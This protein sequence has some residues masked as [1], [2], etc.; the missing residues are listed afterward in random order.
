V[1]FEPVHYDAPSAAEIA[2]AG[3]DVA[4]V[5][6]GPA[7]LTLALALAQREIS[8][9]V[10]EQRDAV[11]IGSRALGLTRRTLDIWEQLGVGDAV[12]SIGRTWYGG[13]SFFREQLILAHELPHDPTLKHAPM[14]NLQQCIAEQ[15]LV[16]AAIASPYI[17][18]AWRHRFTGIA[19]HDEGVTLDLEAPD[20]APRIEARY[21]V[22]CDGAR[23]PVRTALGLHMDGTS[24]GSVYVICDITL[25]S[26]RR[27]ERYAW[28]DAR[29][30]PGSTV[31]MHGQPRDIWRIDYQLP[32]GA[33]LE[34]ALEPANV[35]AFV[36][37]HLKAIG[38]S[39][40]WEIVWISSYRAHS[41][42]MRDYRNG[43]VFFSGD[44]A[45]LLPI[46]GIRGLNSG[47]EDSWNLA[48][49]LARVIAGD[50]PDALLDSYSAER[51]PAAR[52]NLTEA[53]RAARFM[54][55]PTRG[56]RRM[57]DAVLSLALSE[58]AVRDIINPRQGSLIALTDSPL[59][60]VNEQPPGNGAP[61]PGEIMPNIRISTPDAG[62]DVFLYD[63]L[64]YEAALIAVLPAGQRMPFNDTVRE[65]RRETPIGAV[66]LDPD[67]VRMRPGFG[68]GSIY[69]VRPDHHIAARFNSLRSA[70]VRAAVTRAL[71]VNDERT[72]ASVPT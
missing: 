38:E 62:A 52:E 64:R 65:L 61:A 58:P 26:T 7:G 59:S 10:I 71:T 24:H 41:L 42:T 14:T 68:P 53:T 49:K 9:V 18:L 23:S 3:C 16:D 22:A 17:T 45:H 55:P 2:N 25:A 57:R 31:L 56:Y 4:I 6:A 34:A 13:R 39:G 20:G 15:L 33:S 43:R 60:S 27:I 51:L 5:G 47:V 69:L 44:A 28:F 72:V 67:A 70:D 40:D 46:F 50:S 12:R 29:S 35:A 11:G 32:E 8:C 36:Q 54:S 63:Q 66:I 21:A 30:N 1:Y 37:R 19:Q 48:W